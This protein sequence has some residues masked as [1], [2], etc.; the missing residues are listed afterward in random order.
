MKS[1]EL[2]GAH[3]RAT[4]VPAAGGRVRR[5]GLRRGD[6]WGPL[7]YDAGAGALTQQPLLSGSYLM[8]PWPGRV[9]GA[10]F[11]WRGRRYEL[12]A[13]HG[14]HSIHGRGVWLPW[15]VDDASDDACRL[16]LALDDGWPFR[17]GAVTQDIRIDG[18]TLEQRVVVSTRADAF[19]AA[20][21]WHPWF[22]RTLAGADDVAVRLPAS[23]VYDAVDLI[24]TGALVPV[25][26]DLD[27]RRGAPVAGRALDACYVL[28]DG[29]ILLDWG[30]LRLRI[31]SSANVRYAV[32]YTTPHAVCVEPQTA[33][34]DAFN[35]TSRGI[36]CGVA[37]VTPDS[38]LTAWTRW[39]VEP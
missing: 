17:G 15:R 9:A 26:A 30:A 3:L 25:T 2:R 35:L 19:P 29:G 11:E 16:S 21:G 31:T 6:A 28:D 33:A 18:P 1:I 32:V 37:V 36:A 4:I 22:R 7:L 8:A 24:P 27:L 34:N 38:P 20:A 10:S 23:R 5:L 39:T 14:P 12:P 13:N